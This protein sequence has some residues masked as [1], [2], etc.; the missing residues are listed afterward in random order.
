M[1]WQD[2]VVN[3]GKSNEVF[4]GNLPLENMEILMDSVWIVG[5]WNGGCSPLDSP[6]HQHL[7]RALVQLLRHSVYH[8]IVH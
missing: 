2:L 4:V 7:P 5:F 1:R 3:G 8:R 6:F